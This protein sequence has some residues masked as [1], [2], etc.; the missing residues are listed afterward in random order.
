MEKN[1]LELLGITQEEFC[2]KAVQ[3]VVTRLFE[4]EKYVSNV[5]DSEIDKRVRQAIDDKVTAVAEKYVAPVISERIDNAV[6]Q[7]TNTYGEP[8]DKKFTFTEYIL[9]RA[10]DWMAERVNYDGKPK[11]KTQDSYGNWKASGTRI[12]YMVD[13]H[14]QYHIETALK[15]ALTQ[16]NNAISEGIVEGVKIKLKELL[17]GL[18]VKAEV[19]K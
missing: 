6:I 17:E 13:K 2:D 10:E 18:K 9:K 5:F 12:E 14:L 11:P 8:V 3:A 4:D 1:T 7:K 15:Q 16:A 19:K